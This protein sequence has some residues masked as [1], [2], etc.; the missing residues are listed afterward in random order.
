MCNLLMTSKLQ[1]AD[2]QNELIEGCD[3]GFIHRVPWEV[4]LDVD[5]SFYE[6]TISCLR[7]DESI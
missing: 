5:G 7:T 1:G 3:H 2:L 6:K 4:A